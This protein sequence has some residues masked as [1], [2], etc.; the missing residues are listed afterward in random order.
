MFGPV[1]PVV[2][3]DD[4]DEAIALAN[5][6]EFGL[7]AYVCTNDLDR[8]LRLSEALEVGMIGVNRGIVSTPAGPFGG[9]KQSG[10]GREGGAEGIKEYLSPRFVNLNA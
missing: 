10:F 1:A 7:V 3:F 9:V 4:E 2:T 5:D 6:T 8:T